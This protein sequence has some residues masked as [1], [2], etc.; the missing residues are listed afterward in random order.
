MGGITKVIEKKVSNAVSIVSDVKIKNDG[1]FEKANLLLTNVKKLQKFIKDE[2]EKVL[3]PLKESMNAFKAMF[4][5]MEDQINGA[6][7]TLRKVIGEYHDK[8]ETERRKKEAEIASKAETGEITEQVALK[9]LDKI[10]E[11]KKGV[12]TGEGRVSFNKIKKVRVLDENLIPDKY[13][14]I[15]MILVRKEALAAV[16]IPGVEVYEETVVATRA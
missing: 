4:A 12:N 9:K 5:P 1:D 11:E 14:V 16:A 13:W 6:E 2:K 15:D 3:N 10:G 7:S 8:K